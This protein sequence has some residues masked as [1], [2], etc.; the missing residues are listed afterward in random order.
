MLKA[1]GKL[2]VS[3]ISAL[4]G[5]V[6]KQHLLLHV[7]SSFDIVFATE[8]AVFDVSRS[9]ELGISRVAINKSARATTN[10]FPFTGRLLFDQ[11]FNISESV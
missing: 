11:R 4:S 6:N 9:S 5:T 1:R 2:L 8:A 7:I 3:F 10:G